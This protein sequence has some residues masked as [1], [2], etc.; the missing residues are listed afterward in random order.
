MQS[1]C[2]YSIGDLES[3]DA[4]SLSCHSLFPI[5]KWGGSFC[6]RR[7]T[8]CYSI[9]STAGPPTEYPVWISTGLN[10]IT[11]LV[12]NPFNNVSC[13]GGP[14]HRAV[15]DKSFTLFTYNLAQQ[16]RSVQ[17]MQPLM[18]AG[19]FWILCLTSIFRAP[20]TRQATFTRSPPRTPTASGVLGGPKVDR[21]TGPSQR[22]CPEIQGFFLHMRAKEYVRSWIWFTSCF[23]DLE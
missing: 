9:P 19:C 3:A 18:H 14:N 21:K 23:F 20:N 2:M 5:E 10:T 12:Q 1:S 4:E 15:H 8:V 13:A 16:R 11:G 7:E 17:K 22:I 6:L